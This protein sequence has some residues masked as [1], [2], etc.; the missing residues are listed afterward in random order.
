M[1][2]KLCFFILTVCKQVSINLLVLPVPMSCCE[3]ESR[4]SYCTLLTCHRLFFPSSKP[5]CHRYNLFGVLCPLHCHSLSPPWLDLWQLHVQICCIS[6]AGRV[7]M[8]AI[9]FL[10]L[11]LVQFLLTFLFVLGSFIPMHSAH[12]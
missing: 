4:S 10:I 11:K 7:L 12:Y 6:A 5:G 1:T 8:H 2:L 9:A 3:R